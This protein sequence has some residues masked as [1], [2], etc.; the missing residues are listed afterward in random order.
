VDRALGKATEAVGKAVMPVANHAAHGD[1]TTCEV[2]GYA[3]A[4]ANHTLF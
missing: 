2:K 4:R 1:D 3:D